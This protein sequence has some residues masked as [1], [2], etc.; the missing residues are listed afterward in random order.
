LPAA[1]LCSTFAVDRDVASSYGILPSTIDNTLDGAFGQ[2]FVPTIFTA[3][4]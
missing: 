2:R 1:C 4:N 3:L